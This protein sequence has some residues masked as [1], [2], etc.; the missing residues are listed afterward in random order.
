MDGGVVER[1][2][3]GA[4]TGVLRE[5]AAWNF[6]ERFVTVSEEEWVTATREGLGVANGRG[7]G[8]VHDKDGWLGAAG[9]YARIHEREGLT[10]RVWQSFPHEHVAGWPTSGCARAWATTTSGSAT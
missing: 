8:A 5:E 7:V 4:P 10:L 1:D 9:I 2:E 3:D 6:R